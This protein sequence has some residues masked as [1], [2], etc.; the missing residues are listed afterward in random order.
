MKVTWTS[1]SWYGFHVSRTGEV[2][3]EW[4]LDRLTSMHLSTSRVLVF[5]AQW[6]KLYHL[7][8]LEWLPRQST[9]LFNAALLLL[10]L[11]KSLAD[12]LHPASPLSTLSI[13]TRPAGQ[14]IEPTTHRTCPEASSAAVAS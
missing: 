11:L 4:H 14:S 7:A 8:W 13:E 3:V 5:I 12:S 10:A 1:V 2:S 6:R 9:I